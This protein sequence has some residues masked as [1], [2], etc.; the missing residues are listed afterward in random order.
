MYVKHYKPE[1][2]IQLTSTSQMDLFLV[3]LD[4]GSITF[5][6]TKTKEN[7]LMGYRFPQINLAWVQPCQ[8][9]PFLRSLKAN[10]SLYYDTI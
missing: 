3:Q 10:H 7:Y 9:K 4:L 2:L 5:G 6:Y 1:D 8:I